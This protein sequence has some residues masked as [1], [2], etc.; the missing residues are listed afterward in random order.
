[1]Y[2]DKHS[3]EPH[4]KRRRMCNQL[5]TSGD[6]GILEL[7]PDGSTIREY[8]WWGGEFAPAELPEIIAARAKGGGGPTG[9]AGTVAAV[10]KSGGPE[11]VAPAPPASTVPVARF[12]SAAPAHVAGTVGAAAKSVGP[13]VSAAAAA[14]AE[15]G[16][17]EN[18]A[19]SPP[20]Q[21]YPR[22]GL[23]ALHPHMLL[24]P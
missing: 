21:L 11:N 5:D 24:A 23:Q 8:R 2:G 20:P 22:Q 16:G 1:M 7:A 18:V 10:A 9:V 17:P 14:V 3:H 19:R 12:A 4:A 15:S 6:I 13:T